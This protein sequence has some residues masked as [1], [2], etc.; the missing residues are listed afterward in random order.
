MS[1]FFKVKAFKKALPKSLAAFTG[2]TTQSL[3][4]KE[5]VQS[6]FRG[7]FRRLTTGTREKPYEIIPAVEQQV[8]QLIEIF[9]RMAIFPQKICIDGMPGAGKSTFGRSLAMRTG[10]KWQTLFWS[11]VRH[12][13]PF[14]HGII[15]ENL[16]LLRTQPIEF[17]DVI[18]YIEAS[19][20][21]ARQRILDRDRNGLLADIVHLPKLKRVG[22]LAFQMLD[23]K[24]IKLENS[25]ARIKVRPPQGF[26]DIQNIKTFLDHKGIDVRTDGYS[27]EELLYACCY[28]KPRKGYF[29]YVNLGAYNDDILR[30]LGA[31]LDKTL[32]RVIH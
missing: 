30:G 3:L 11:E 25:S 6:F 8:D 29:P 27:K 19:P 31:A 1:S 13:Y 10:L 9:D 23:G 17:F 18:I 22:D 12:P 20:E 28:G 4:E 24:E 14:K 7:Q 16:R 26:N 32:R 5:T 21:V 15:Y 2:T